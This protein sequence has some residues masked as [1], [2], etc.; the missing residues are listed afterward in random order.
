M[1]GIVVAMAIIVILL[2]AVGPTVATIIERDREKELIFRGRQY[3]RAVLAFQRRYGRFP[4]ALTELSKV[5]PRS[6]R[7]L[8]KDP[9]CNCDDW[10]LIIVGSPEA[11]PMGAAPPPGGSGPGLNSRTPGAGQ[12]TP[13]PGF[14]GDLT[15]TPGF[16]GGA[17]SPPVTPTPGSSVFGPQTGQPV[18]PIIGVR[19]K[20]RRKAIFDWR[21]RSYTTE[22]RFI[23]G[24]ADNENAPTFDPNIL[25]GPKYTPPPSGGR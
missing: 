14:G 12:K 2:A 23:A 19:T 11:M 3:A 1:V 18:G 15:P 10:Q 6:I 4:N 13:T 7:K 22:W 24:D 16:M 21:G 8:W 25:R 17:G 9:M 5:K 20:V